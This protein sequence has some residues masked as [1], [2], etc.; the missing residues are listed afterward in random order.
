MKVT[1]NHQVAV[2]P[3]Q[4]RLALMGKHREQSM[5][6]QEQP[7]PVLKPSLGMGQEVD[8]AR[9]KQ[10]LTKERERVQKYQIRITEIHTTYRVNGQIVSSKVD[11]QVSPV[12]RVEQQAKHNFNMHAA[13]AHDMKQLGMSF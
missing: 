12:Q 8:D 3:E 4:T 11:R 1:F 6:E 2:S 13:Q 5:M 10:R 7:V 9:Y